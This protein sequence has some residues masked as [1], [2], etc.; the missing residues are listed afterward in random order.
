VC[1]RWQPGHSPMVVG[2]SESA[3]GTVEGSEGA[4]VSGINLSWQN[5]PKYLNTLVS[6]DMFRFSYDH[7]R[8]VEW[9]R[10]QSPPVF[11]TNR[12]PTPVVSWCYL[13]CSF[14]PRTKKRANP[15]AVALRSSA[16]LRLNSYS[17]LDSCC[18]YS[19]HRPHSCHLMKNRHVVSKNSSARGW[20]HRARSSVDEKS[21]SHALRNGHTLRERSGPGFLPGHRL[22]VIP[23]YRQRCMSAKSTSISPTSPRCHQLPSQPERSRTS[24][25]CW[26]RLEFARSVSTTCATHSGRC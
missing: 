20:V 14:S 19:M 5:T 18:S 17:A 15:E 2:R 11:G 23:L 22:T 10:S 12:K 24:F 8:Y 1:W 3:E 4:S 13:V 25:R 26:R 6:S 21:P 16:I 7:G 9:A